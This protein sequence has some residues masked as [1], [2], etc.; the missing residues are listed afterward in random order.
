MGDCAVNLVKS[1]SYYTSDGRKIIEAIF[2]VTLSNS[3]ASGGDTLDL[4]KYF[5]EIDIIEIETPIVGSYLVEV[6]R[7]NK[8]VKAYS[9]VGTEVTG[10]TDLSG[11]TFRIRVVGTG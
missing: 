6:D 9:D 3:Y 11:V 8:K 7:V 5:K 10:G 2:D 4:S 1:R